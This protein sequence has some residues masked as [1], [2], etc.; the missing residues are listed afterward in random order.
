MDLKVKVINIEHP[1]RVALINKEDAGIIGVGSGQRII[2]GHGST[3]LI[4]FVYLSDIVGNGEIW[5]NERL[6]KDLN[7]GNGENVSVFSAPQPQSID[8]IRKKMYGNKL[9]KDEIDTIVRDIVMENLSDIELSAYVSSIQTIGLDSEEITNMV[10]AMVN[11]GETI[12]FDHDV[13]DVHS[14]GGIPGNKYALLTVPIVASAGLKIP[15]TS[16][17]AISS[18]AGTA[19]VMEVLARVDLKANEIKK[20]VEEVGGTL[21]WGG[22]MNLAPADDKIIRVEHP[23]GI[24][25]YPQVI[26][27]VL[28]KKKATGINY[29]LIDIPM[30]PETKVQNEERAR[31]LASRF[32]EIGNRLNIHVEC[33]I[34]YG[35]QPLGRAVGPALE[36]MEAM[37]ALEGIPTSNSMIVK[38]I[39]LA[40]M[41]IEMGGV[42]E[43]NKG[44][45]LARQILN[46]GRAREKFLEIIN[47]QGSKGIEK[48]DE[49]PVGEFQ[50]DLTSSM[51]G[52]ISYV[53]NRSIVQLARSLGAPK[54]KGA[55]IW[56]YKKIGDKVERNET[57]LKFYAEKKDKLENTVRLSRKFRI[58]DVEGMVLESIGRK[59]R[60]VMKNED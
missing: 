56:V 18:P 11:A 49:I 15:K 51:D 55:G 52:Y 53:S 40:S 58:F 45:D 21:T 36:A 31:D 1:K 3:D 29:L 12:K 25:P 34:T 17:R 43:F 13:Y 41:I 10:N 6:S 9:T 59:T 47:A 16:S 19:D 14:I 50:Y 33:A 20:I 2:V 60:G 24:D 30:G 57:V 48:S 7:V 46:S 5:I 42:A 32:I 8:Y 39:E 26:A 4:A 22:A 23:L 54:D 28:A 37:K 35:G 44:K 38:A 27:S